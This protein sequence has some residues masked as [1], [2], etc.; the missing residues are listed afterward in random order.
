MLTESFTNFIACK[1]VF[2]VFPP[3][4]VLLFR[5]VICLAILWCI[6]RGKPRPHV[7]R[8]DRKWIIVVGMV[9][10]ILGEIRQRQE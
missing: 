1:Y 9:Y 8:E 10:T 4:T 3:V 7:R 2:A 6:Y 5:Y